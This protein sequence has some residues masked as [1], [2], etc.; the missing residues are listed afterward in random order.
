MRT[1][2]VHHIPILSAI[3]PHIYILLAVDHAMKSC[4]RIYHYRRDRQSVRKLFICNSHG[5]SSNDLSFYMHCYLSQLKKK[6]WKFVSMRHHVR[7]AAERQVSRPAF[8]L[9]ILS[10][11]TEAN[12]NMK[13]FFFQYDTSAIISRM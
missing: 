13:T 10:R 4:A 2:T 7:H 8:S 3:S 1:V 12:M 5:N 6:A 11:Y 9:L